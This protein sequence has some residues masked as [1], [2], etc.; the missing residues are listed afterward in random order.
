M[1]T[2]A[3]HQQC[4]NWCTLELQLQFAISFGLGLTHSKKLF[5]NF[6]II[7]LISISTG[8][9]FCKTLPAAMQNGFMVKDPKHSITKT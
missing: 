2:K 6:I 5:G 8:Q 1:L 7:F 3:C 9:A 4:R